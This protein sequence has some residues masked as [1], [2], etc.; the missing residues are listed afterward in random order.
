MKLELKICISY[1]VWRFSE[2]QLSDWYFIMALSMG[3]CDWLVLLV[4]R[5]RS[6]E[7]HRRPSVAAGHCSRWHRA[8][9]GGKP[10]VHTHTRFISGSCEVLSN[11]NFL[12]GGV[13]CAIFIGLAHINSYSHSCTSTQDDLLNY[14]F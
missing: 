8:F 9:L 2:E 6:A 1:Q 4:L 5:G 13:E 7:S 11:Y 14:A 3:Y 12:C 10:D